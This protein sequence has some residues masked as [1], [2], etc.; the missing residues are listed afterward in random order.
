MNTSINEINDK[1]VRET[2]EYDDANIDTII[3]NLSSV[4]SKLDDI[5]TKVSALTSI[6]A[7]WKGEAKEIHGELKYFITQYVKD[8]RN[9]IN[10]LKGT[11]EGLQTLLGSI[12]QSKVIK[13]IK[14]A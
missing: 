12:S 13:E 10:E 6:D 9:S 4:E 5:E 3:S 11:I 2:I 8:Y 14:D 7:S 1:Y